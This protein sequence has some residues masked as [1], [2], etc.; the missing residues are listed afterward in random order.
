MEAYTP[1]VNVHAALIFV[2]SLHFLLRD[3][4]R[5]CNMFQDKPRHSIF[6]FFLAAV[7]PPCTL[8]D[9][10]NCPVLQLPDLV[11]WVTAAPEAVW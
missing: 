1:S 11:W 9:D 10:M 2:A 7:L 4:N 6:N 3:L 5:Y 8:Q